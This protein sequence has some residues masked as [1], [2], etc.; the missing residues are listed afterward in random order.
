M[1]NS[2]T[3]AVQP[4]P[5][6]MFHFNL[7]GSAHRFR[8]FFMDCMVSVAV[9]VKKRIADHAYNVSILLLLVREGEVIFTPVRQ[10]VWPS[11][12]PF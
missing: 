3:I 10:T 7:K 1:Q 2:T 11:V 9:F 6:D 5:V 12:N 8:M 4:W